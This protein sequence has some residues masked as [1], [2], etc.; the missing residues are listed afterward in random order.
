[1]FVRISLVNV[2]SLALGLFLLWPSPG[3]AATNDLTLTEANNGQT[4]QAM[5]QQSILVQLR[6]NATTGYTWLL[7]ST[8]GNSVTVAGPCS[9]APEAGGAVGAGGTFTF[10]F[11]AATPGPTTLSFSYARS[12]DPGDVAQSFSVTVNVT[13]EALLPRLDI[14]LQGGNARISW[15]TNGSTAFF[16]EGNQDLSGGW[17]A[18][19]VLPRLEESNY[20]VTLPTSGQFLF[21]RLRR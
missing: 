11:L 18:L 2:S 12:W 9:Y 3:H 16:L 19:N 15:P 21:F 6:G 1:M 13:A 4:V 20:V 8:N 5:V 10:P 14:E 17:A 7:A